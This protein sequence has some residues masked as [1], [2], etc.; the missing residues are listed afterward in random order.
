M[1]LVSFNKDSQPFKFI[2]DVLIFEIES[3]KELSSL[4]VEVN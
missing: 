3:L 2:I 4:A 1:L